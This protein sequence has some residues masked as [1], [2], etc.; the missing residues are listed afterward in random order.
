[1]SELLTTKQLQ[2]LLKVDR[3]TVYRMLNDGRL[4]GLKI[5]NQWRFPQS[6]IDRLM[7]EERELEEPQPNDEVLT[8]F[9]KDCVERVVSIFA[10][11]IGIGATTVTLRGDPLTEPT[12]ANPFCK[13]MQS[14]PSGR[15][16]CQASW[17]KIALRTTGMPPFQ[18][19]HAGLCY[20]RAIINLNDQPAAWLVAGQFYINPPDRGH[21]KEHLTQLANKHNI[22]LSQLTEAAWKIP[23]LKKYQQEQVQEWTPKVADTIHSILCER[24]D[25]MSR[26]QRIAEL[27]SVHSTLS[28]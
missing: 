22:P 6:E 3:I 16:A 1:M 20:Q 14:S 13:L 27:S 21:E 8:D 19:C 9:P 11:I 18:V 23:V 26:L 4:K 12:Y 24:S 5:G 17:R 7:G 28:K 15:Q 2:E 10:G 25:L